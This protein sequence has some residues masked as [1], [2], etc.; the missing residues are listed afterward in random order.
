MLA[1][2]S[3]VSGPISTPVPTPAF[4]N[5]AMEAILHAIPEAVDDDSSTLPSPPSSTLASRTISSTSSSPASSSSATSSSTAPPRTGRERLTPA[6]PAFS[7]LVVHEFKNWGSLDTETKEKCIGLEPCKYKY[8]DM[9]AWPAAGILRATWNQTISKTILDI[10]ND[11]ETQSVLRGFFCRR[12]KVISFRPMLFLLSSSGQRLEAT[13]HV[14]FLC[15]KKYLKASLRAIQVL[16]QHKCMQ[17]Y[18]FGYVREIDEIELSA[19]DTP[20]L[21]GVRDVDQDNNS[22]CGKAV[23]AC[24]FPCTSASKS[25][26]ATVGG[27]LNAGPHDYFAMT[28]AHVFFDFPDAQGDSNSDSDLDSDSEGTTSSTSTTSSDPCHSQS[29]IE[30]P[31]PHGVFRSLQSSPMT[32]RQIS[33]S[34]DSD[35]QLNTATHVGNAFANSISSLPPK[36]LLFNRDLDWALVQIT[37]P[38]LWCENNFHDA[39]LHARPQLGRSID[40]PLDGDVLIVAELLENRRG[41][42]LGTK[43]AINLPWTKGFV[44]V[45]AI[46]CESGRFSTDVDVNPKC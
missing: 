34:A 4:F 25:R 5:S 1:Y 13:P 30:T 42:S 12:R 19:T 24:P 32:S 35:A 14:V 16:E 17:S 11:E 15:G 29:P 6:T 21:S 41:R 3:L 9:H 27:I 31:A 22:L 7:S 18:N 28:C 39:G 45:W 10:L 33:K 43:A 44:E 37:D 46:E 8:G 2:H 36:E 38:R 40:D 26:L 20:V 23:P